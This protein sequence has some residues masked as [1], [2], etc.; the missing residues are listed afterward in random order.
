MGLSILD[1]SIVGYLCTIFLIGNLL[2]K[3]IRDSVTDPK[4]FIYLVHIQF[5]S[6]V[7]YFME[8]KLEI[9]VLLFASFIIFMFSL[10]LASFLY[11]RVRPSR[12]EINIQEFIPSITLIF[13]FIIAW[14]IYSTAYNAYLYG[15]L[16]RSLVR[17]YIL[18]PVNDSIPYLTFID[19]VGAKFCVA[20]ILLL[21]YLSTKYGKTYLYLYVSVIIYYLAVIPLGTR[22]N[23]ILIAIAVILG[24]LLGKGCVFKLGFKLLPVILIA[25]ISFLFLS[26]NRGNNF[27]E[28]DT[29]IYSSSTDY[30]YVEVSQE[31]PIV[32][33]HID[34]ALEHYRNS[35]NFLYFNTLYSIV[36]NP[37]PRKFWESKPIGIGKIMAMNINNDPETPISFAV[38][39]SGE[40][41]V[42]NGI[43]GVIYMSLLAGGITGFL[44]SKCLE[45]RHYIT[46]P[47]DIIKY[48]L[49]FNASILF[50]RG[51]MLSAW[52]LSIYPII[53]FYI[54]IYGYR[55]LRKLK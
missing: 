25:C 45:I 48:L 18:K 36:V 55:L 2:K 1:I 51:D 23:V 49:F 37:I 3:G 26:L 15:G 10:E 39:Y 35:D 19:R 33:K 46:S 38:S 8:N 28:N 40:G 6:V 34:L 14:S 20:L 7:P 29:I 54:V 31:V 21:S 53:M 17:F 12:N 13:I 41:W 42:N 5:L 50:I 30:S 9:E 44:R 16:D 22:G 52:S 11:F 27:I 47:V 24:G 43:F 32:I 4:T